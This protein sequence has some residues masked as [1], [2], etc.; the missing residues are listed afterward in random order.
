MTASSN[1]VVIEQP[2]SRSARSVPD[3]IGALDMTKGVLVV[4][5]V[6]YHSFNYSADYTLGFKFIP[7]LPP[8]FIVITGFL[9]SHLNPVSNDGVRLRSSGR[10]IF[11][12]FRLLALFI[13]L[14]IATQLAGGGKSSHEAQGVSY[15]FDHWFEVFGFGEGRYASFL[16]LLPIA[17]L[18]LL[19]PILV[20]L[21]RWTPVLIPALV[22]SLAV[23][24][25][26][27]GIYNELPVNLG[28][29]FAGLVGFS[30]G[31]LPNTSLLY[32]KRYWFIAVFF[33][34]IFLLVSHFAGRT[35]LNQLFDACLALAA[36]F[37]VCSAVGEY[38][39]PGQRLVALGKY[40]LFSYILQ[41]AVL[42]ILSRFVGRLMP[43]SLEF[44]LQMILVLVG[45]MISVEALHYGRRKN[46]FVDRSYKAVF[47]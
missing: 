35:P 45:L 13:I 34:T 44:F 40:S 39:L 47:A 17:Y 11:R 41:L 3:R 37:G 43:F 24:C 19:A 38:S 26:W 6:V 5:M 27:A 23:L 14:N 8:S 12:G 29:L 21:D 18:L 33:Y 2:V 4:L 31:R 36:I 16:I 28:L 32:L 15:F 22:V 42:Q 20:I 1:A 9:I 30:L 10:F 7:F 46:W 25:A